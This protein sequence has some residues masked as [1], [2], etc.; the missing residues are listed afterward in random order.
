MGFKNVLNA[1]WKVAVVVAAVAILAVGWL[2]GAGDRLAI[3]IASVT[4][5]E[6]LDTVFLFPSRG[7]I[8]DCNGRV[9]ATNRVVHDIY[10]D[11]SVDMEDADWMAK[12]DSLAK[13]LSALF[14]DR[15][16]G[17][18]LSIMTS[19]R[20]KGKRYLRIRRNVDSLTIERVRSLPLFNESRSGGLLVESRTVRDYP[21]GPLAGRT[22]GLFRGGVIHDCDNII[23]LEAKYDEY[24]AGNIGYQIRKNGKDGKSAKAVRTTRPVDG[25][26]LL[27]SL[28]IALQAK[29][30]SVLRAH[31]GGEEDIE[32]ACLVIMR[33]ANG[34]IRTVVNL[35]RDKEFG[36]FRELYNVAI[37]HQFE[38]GVLL[39]PATMLTS[40][41]L[42]NVPSLDERTPA[43]QGQTY[44][45]TLRNILA[46][47]KTLET[48]DIDG[49]RPICL[50]GPPDNTRS[51]AS[52]GPLGFGYGMTASCLD[53]LAFYN[54]IA[55]GGEAVC[56]RLLENAGTD[57][58]RVCTKAQ[59]GE[60]TEDLVQ[61][62]AGTGLQDA[63]CTVA[64]MSGV[65]KEAFPGGTYSDSRGRQKFV[66]TFAGFFPAE[67]PE[68]SIICMAYTKPTGSFHGQT[69]PA[70]TVKTLLDL[71]Y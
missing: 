44:V 14:G 40:M 51:V 54:A 24:L 56:P 5:P 34:K 11:P 47:G 18:Y 2:T 15:S 66:T 26:D 8:L 30:D 7:D 48:W 25:K 35:V 39:A 22:L 52:P 36:D 71:I 64:G 13:G 65:A 31:I 20:E 63:P 4:S 46:G 41:K 9:L 12:A 53:F 38:P 50:P 49:L 43:D 68:Y 23:G 17:K 42:G 27:T 1:G 57:T 62:A 60:L 21:Y 58:Y 16:P 33:T 55:R 45:D 29:A 6:V 28:D 3:H 32:G 59:A 69:L 19:G 61:A 67:A 10:M 37:G 70:R